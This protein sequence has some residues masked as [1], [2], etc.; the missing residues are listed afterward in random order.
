MTPYERDLLWQTV[1]ERWDAVINTYKSCLEHIHKM[2][3]QNN[4]QLGYEQMEFDISTG[5]EEA[6]CNET[7]P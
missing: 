7:D 4:E 2:K 3:E 1:I 5:V 6:G